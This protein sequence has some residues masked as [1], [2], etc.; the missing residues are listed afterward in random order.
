[1]LI[2]LKLAMVIRKIQFDEWLFAVAAGLSLF[3]V[4]MVY[5]ASAPM[6]TQQGS[7]YYFVTKQAAWAG[8]GIIGLF[9]GLLIDY[10]WLNDKRLVYGSILVLVLLLL[11]VLEFPKINGAH[12]WI[13]YGSFSLQPSELAKITL[14]LFLAH[15]LSRRLEHQTQHVAENVDYNLPFF[16]GFLPCLFVTGLLAGLIVI[17]PDL[18]TALMLCVPCLILTL[19][20]G[21][22]LRYLLMASAPALLC[23]L[24]LLIFVPWRMKRLIMFLDP[25]AD[26]QGAGYQV[27]QSLIAVGTGGTGGVGFAEGKQK[28]F[29]LPFAHSDFIFS[30]VSE[31]L[32]LIGAGV[33]LLLFGLLLWRGLR[34]SLRAPDMFGMLLG[35]GIVTM[36][37]TQALLNISVALSLVPTKG[38]PLPFISYGGSSIVPMLFSIGVLLNISQYSNTTNLA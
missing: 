28:F 34:I 37:V 32:G 26:P 12:R 9:V 4:V 31:E 14:V 33:V 21:V 5:S 19:I 23:V 8:L 7:P 36:I 1:M 10:R 29:F 3:G 20:S 25:W 18:G 22:R 6:A 27:V 16:T 11:A 15:F 30:V 38:I 24:S 17:E 2:D 13:R 35:V